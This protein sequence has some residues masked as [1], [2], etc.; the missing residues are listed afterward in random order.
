MCHVNA[1]IHCFCNR[2]T[3]IVLIQHA[4][5]WIAGIYIHVYSLLGEL[6]ICGFIAGMSS[7]GGE[8]MGKTGGEPISG[9]MPNEA[10]PDWP[11]PFCGSIH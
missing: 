3:V 9:D 5:A 2:V 10:F 6:N 11:V 8:R 1:L 7:D 4:D